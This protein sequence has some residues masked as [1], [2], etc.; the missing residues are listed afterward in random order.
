[1]RLAG[2]PKPRSR[3]KRALFISSPIGLGHARRDVAI[4]AEL[5]ARAK[6]FIGQKSRPGE[7]IGREIREHIRH[8]RRMGLSQQ[9]EQF[10]QDLGNRQ[11]EFSK[12]YPSLYL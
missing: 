2:P 8:L 7:R 9:G 12:T 1:M 3:R 4:A 5:R 10:N 11:Y 6:R